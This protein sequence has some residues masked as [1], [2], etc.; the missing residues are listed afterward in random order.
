MLDLFVLKTTIIG[1]CNALQLNVYIGSFL[2]SPYL[3]R[4]K[5]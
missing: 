5:A 4:S 1:R 3:Q 2:V